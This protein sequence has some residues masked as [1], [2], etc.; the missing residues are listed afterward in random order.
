MSSTQLERELEPGPAAPAAAASPT[1]TP[2]TKTETKAEQP[3]TALERITSCA[4]QL[5][6]PGAI[7]PF[8][9]AAIGAVTTPERRHQYIFKFLARPMPLPGK[10]HYWAMV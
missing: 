2:E 9:P 3:G 10:Y 7:E 4:S 1:H 5:Y 8:A 6:V